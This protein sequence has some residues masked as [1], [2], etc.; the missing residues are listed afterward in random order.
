MRGAG[1]PFSSSAYFINGVESPAIQLQGVD[2]T[3]ANTEYFYKFDQ[4]HSSNSGHPLR[5][6]KDAAKSEAY[7]TG[8]TTNGTAGSSGAYT[9]IA[10]DDATPNVLYYQCSSHSYMGNYVTTPSSSV[11]GLDDAELTALAGLTSAADKGIQFTG[12]G[13]AGT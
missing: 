10:V 8:V 4:S 9:T 2:G 13:T 3:T 11:Q 5:F 12:S 1:W 6:Y 7:T